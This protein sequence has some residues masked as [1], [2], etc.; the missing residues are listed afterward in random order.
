MSRPAVL[1]NL[2]EDTFTVL[3][4]SPSRLVDWPKVTKLYSQ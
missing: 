2:T 1:A 4:D 3:V